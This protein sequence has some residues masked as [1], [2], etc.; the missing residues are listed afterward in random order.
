MSHKLNNKHLF[1]AVLE[2]GKSK[3]KILADLLSGYIFSL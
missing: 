1:L 3:T 2:A